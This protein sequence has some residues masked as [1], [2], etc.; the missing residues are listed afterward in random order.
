MAFLLGQLYTKQEVPV[1]HV[2][3]DTEVFDTLSLFMITIDIPAPLSDL[4][5]RLFSQPVSHL[6][7]RGMSWLWTAAT[8]RRSTCLTFRQTLR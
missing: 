8:G 2:Y 1:G 3:A 6:L 4:L 7:R 5:V